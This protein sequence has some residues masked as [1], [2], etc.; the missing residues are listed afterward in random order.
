[1]NLKLNGQFSNKSR[2]IVIIREVTGHKS[3]RNNYTVV[4]YNSDKK[5]K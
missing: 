3:N 5:I 4:Q 2:R 1:M